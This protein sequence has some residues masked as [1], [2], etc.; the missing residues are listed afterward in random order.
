MFASF[1]HLAPEEIADIAWTG[2]YYTTGFL[3]DTLQYLYE[4]ADRFPQ[5]LTYLKE[6]Q[7][8]AYFKKYVTQYPIA[9]KYGSFDGAENDVGIVYTEEPYLLAVYTYGLADGEEVVARVNEAVCRYNTEKATRASAAAREAARLAKLAADEQRFA[10]ADR[11]PAEA[12]QPTP[13]P[14]YLQDLSPSAWAHCW[15]WGPPPD[16]CSGSSSTTGA[17]GRCILKRE[18]P[19]PCGAQKKTCGCSAGLFLLGGASAAGAFSAAAAAVILAAAA[20]V[21]AIAA[22]V[23]TAPADKDD[24]QDN[25]PPPT[26]PISKNA[27]IARHKRTSS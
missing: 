3:C 26:V 19:P 1:S 10:Q 12:P 13:Q 27:G 6:A 8:E 11:E 18:T 15:P 9:H 24:N 17:N 2:N 5:L 16:C 25:D 21:T 14:A 20:V 4:N 22:A 7:P 23:I